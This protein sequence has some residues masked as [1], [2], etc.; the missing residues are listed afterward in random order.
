MV[1]RESKSCNKQDITAKPIQ[2][3]TTQEINKAI[4]QAKTGKAAGHNQQQLII[5]TLSN[6]V[7]EKLNQTMNLVSV[8]EKLQIISRISTQ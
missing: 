7:K 2:L 4:G 1:D 6:K 5:K 8:M 3:R